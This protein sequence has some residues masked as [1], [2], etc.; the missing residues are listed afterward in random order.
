MRF[1]HLLLG[2][3]LFAGLRLTWDA[4]PKEI[5]TEKPIAWGY[6]W[7]GPLELRPKPTPRSAGF[8]RLAAGTLAPVLKL[9]SKQGT[10]WTRVR[11]LDLTKLTPQEG[12]VESSQME[13]LPSERFPADA[14]LL[15]QL[16]GAYLDDFA[17][18][19]TDIA[20]F[21]VR[22]GKADPVL[23]CFV[24]SSVLPSARL[25]V[26]VPT[27]GKLAPGPSLEFPSSEI[28]AAIIAVEVRDLLGDGNECLVTREP[29]R[30]G[31]ETRGVNMVIRRIEGG[32]FKTLWKAPL[33]F[34]NLGSFPPRAQVLQ[35]PE[36]NI[37]TEGTVTLG[38][39]SFRL[40]GRVYE[41][42]WKGKVE[43]YV[44]GR[45]QPLESVAIEKVC[46]WEGARFTS[47]H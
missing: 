1:R 23:V 17:A 26:F 16:G 46:S 22:Q 36:R 45:E 37:G 5:K 15:R 38:E 8:A 4:H 18:S 9:D 34:R 10:K 47:L 28:Q 11:V 20:R 40:R 14:D 31:P 21:L 24:I 3:L 39:V 35:P 41:P 2:L 13:L 43:F 33:E 29:F 7:S 19:H 42:V 30:L 12:W 6:V 44:L 25:V 27:G 32:V